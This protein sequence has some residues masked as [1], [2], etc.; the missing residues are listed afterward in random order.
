MLQPKPKRP[1]IKIA[2]NDDA[3][4]NRMLLT[5]G[6]EYVKGNYRNNV[7]HKNGITPQAVEDCRR[8]LIQSENLLWILLYIMNL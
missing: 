5:K 1:A 7:A 4:F 3:E 6:L 2:F 8:I